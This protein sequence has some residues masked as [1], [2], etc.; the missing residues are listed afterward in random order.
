MICY[1]ISY[2]QL[3]GRS[4][5]CDHITHTKPKSHELLTDYSTP[6]LSTLCSSSWNPN[7]RHI[8]HSN[9]QLNQPPME[10]DP[11]PRTEWTQLPIR[12]LLQSVWQCRDASQHHRYSQHCY[13]TESNVLH[14]VFHLHSG[15]ER[16][17]NGASF[18]H[19]PSHN[20]SC[21]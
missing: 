20:S 5:L 7:E 15:T 10:H 14:N 6:S 9:I 2:I 11:F 16:C 19:N 18:T 21:P 17:R 3:L 13:Y 8:P 12:C 4:S 1:C